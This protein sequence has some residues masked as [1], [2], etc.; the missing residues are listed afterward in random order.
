MR[1]HWSYNG[2]VVTN[3]D[4]VLGQMRLIRNSVR[5]N[6][7]EGY[8]EYAVS[9]FYHSR[10]ALFPGTPIYNFLSLDS[11]GYTLTVNALIHNRRIRHDVLMNI[12]NAT[13]MNPPPQRI[14][15][16]AQSYGVDLPTLSEMFLQGRMTDAD[17][18]IVLDFIK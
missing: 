2:E 6:V 17:V 10:L 12:D 14:V 3:P 13:V 4:R 8:D 1:K 15:Q 11:G 7:Q 16:L 5:S 18:A 9:D